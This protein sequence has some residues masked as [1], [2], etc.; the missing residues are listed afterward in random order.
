[1]MGSVLSGPPFKLDFLVSANVYQVLGAILVGGES[2]HA[3][4]M[5]ESYR[6]Y[7]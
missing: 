2:L 6:M 1:M 4:H 5:S 7:K 3:N